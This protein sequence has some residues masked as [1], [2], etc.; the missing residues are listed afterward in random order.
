MITIH[1]FTL[2]ADANLICRIEI[3][4]LIQLLDIGHKQSD[5]INKL[6][7]WASV[8]TNS[9]QSSTIE[10]DIEGTGIE[11]LRTPPNKI[12]I[13][14]KSICSGPYVW[15]VFKLEDKKEI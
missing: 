13:F 12:R 4:G 9:P 2:Q 1:R 15:H 14:W 6:S 3:P 10:L 7:L 11:I 5:A 8:D